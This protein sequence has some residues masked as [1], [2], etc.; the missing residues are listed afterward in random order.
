M[1]RFLYYIY[2]VAI[3]SLFFATTSCEHKDLCYHHPHSVK[4]IVKFDWSK[5]PDANPAGMCVYFYP[6]DGGEARRF[7]FSGR[8]GGEIEINIGNYRAIAYNNDTEAVRYANG[9]FE[10][11]RLYTREGGLLEPME[12]SGDFRPTLPEE[13]QSNKV[14]ITPDQVWGASAEMIEIT[15]NGTYYEHETITGDMS[16]PSLKVDNTGEIVEITFTPEDVMCHYSYEYLNVNNLSAN[17]R[18]S[19]ALTGMSGVY[20]PG[21]WKLHTDCVTL[22]FEAMSDRS[23]RIFGQFLTFGHHEENTQPHKMVLYVVSADKDGKPIAR[24]YTTDVTDQVHGAP[25]PRR[26]HIVINDTINLPE[27]IDGGSGFT[28][29][30]DDWEVVEEDIIM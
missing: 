29:T 13:A 8:E 21:L 30:V 16:G 20:Y 26:V 27:P 11:H 22:P 4:I 25:N 17:Q 15:D 24:A 3:V 18:L 12:I 10:T 5:A 9:A 23:S 7:D 28:P 6:E 19:A 14:V 1:K 2:C